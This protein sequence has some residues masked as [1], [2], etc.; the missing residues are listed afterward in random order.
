MRGGMRRDIQN[1]P[2]ILEDYIQIIHIPVQFCRHKL[3]HPDINTK[4]H[5]KQK[6]AVKPSM[7]QK[8]WPNPSW[9][10]SIQLE[11]QLSQLRFWLIPQRRRCFPGKFLGSKTA[12]RVGQTGESKQKI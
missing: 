2:P 6:W 8:M 12:W 1:P 10:F 4:F 5:I 11:R 3:L 9:K 7:Y